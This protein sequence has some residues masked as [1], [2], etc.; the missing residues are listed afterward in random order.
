MVYINRTLCDVLEEMRKCY[1]TRN[2]CSINGLI[3]EAQAMGNRMEAGL[4]DKGDFERWHKQRA[5]VYKE[6]EDLKDQV[7]AKQA[8]LK[9]LEES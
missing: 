8:E 4:E 9:K 2:F 5:E 3:E 7:D 6:L 1:E